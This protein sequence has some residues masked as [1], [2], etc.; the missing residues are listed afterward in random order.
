MRRSLTGEVYIARFAARLPDPAIRTTTVPTWILPVAIIATGL[1]YL[2]LA[3]HEHGAAAAIEQS[4]RPTI[5]KE[6]VPAGVEYVH[7]AASV[8]S[9]RPLPPVFSSASFRFG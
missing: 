6:I 8:G 5:A 7:S 2:T 1:A 3:W 4:R 9:A